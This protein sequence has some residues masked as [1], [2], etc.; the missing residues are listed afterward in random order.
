MFGH[1]LWTDSKSQRG[2]LGIR[3]DSSG[4]LTHDALCAVMSVRSAGECWID[5]VAFVGFSC[6]DNS[7]AWLGRS[8]ICRRDDPPAEP[9]KVVIVV[10]TKYIC[11]CLSFALTSVVLRQKELEPDFQHLEGTRR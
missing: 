1:F 10:M 2:M 8:V 4:C 7:G 3:I 6:L 9:S 11:C 5:W